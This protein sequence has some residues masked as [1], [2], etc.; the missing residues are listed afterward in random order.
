MNKA[1][2]LFV[3]ALITPKNAVVKQAEQLSRSQKVKPI[4]VTKAAQNNYVFSSS[5]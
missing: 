2:R 4:S 5:Y 1:S 3:P